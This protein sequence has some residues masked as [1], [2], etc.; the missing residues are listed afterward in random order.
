MKQVT[1][2][3][4]DFKDIKEITKE[5][6][7][8]VLNGI[9]AALISLGETLKKSTEVKPIEEVKTTDAEVKSEEVK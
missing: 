2:N 4:P 3:V 5:T 1:I 8:E 9:G 6:S 7:K